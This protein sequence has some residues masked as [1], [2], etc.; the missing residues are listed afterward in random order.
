MLASRNTGWYHDLR[1]SPIRPA[2]DH[3]GRPTNCK[4]V[5]LVAKDG[6]RT[7]Q[8][9]SGCNLK[10]FRQ[11][12]PAGDGLHTEVSVTDPEPC[13]RRCSTTALP[14]S[15]RGRPVTTSSGNRA[16]VRPAVWANGRRS[17]STAVPMAMR[18]PY[19]SS[20]LLGGSGDR[21]SSFRRPLLIPDLVIPD[22]VV[23]EPP[24]HARSDR[25]RRANT[26]TPAAGQLARITTGQWL[27]GGRN[28]QP[29][30][31]TSNLWTIALSQAATG[32]FC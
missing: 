28:D 12:G 7:I 4:A 20:V 30:Q 18:P 6:D 32:V 3:A 13:E 24:C 1:R 22:L 27:I 14:T 5:T 25:S 11:E 29:N 31:R 17:H 15:W 8:M 21:T 9:A 19:T 2:S 10:P 16:G 23:L 26:S